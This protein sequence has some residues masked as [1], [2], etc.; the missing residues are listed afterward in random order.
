LGE[1]IEMGR[2]LIAF[3]QRERVAEKI[4]ELLWGYTHGGFSYV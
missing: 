3:E 2:N 4:M 1:E